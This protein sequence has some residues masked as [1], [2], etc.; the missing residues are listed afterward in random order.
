MWTQSLTPAS[1][2]DWLPTGRPGLRQLVD[3]ARD[4]GRDL[5]R[6]V[7]V[8]VDPQRVVLL[9]HRAELVVDPLRQEHRHA[10]ADPDDLDVGD[11]AMPR[12]IFSKSFGARVRP[13]PPEISTSRTC[14]VG[15]GTRAG[16]RGRAS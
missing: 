15:G 11:L 2:T 14:G 6:V 8:E 4:L 10:R 16:P 7:E 5:V 13:S 12:R 1:R 9:E 3:R